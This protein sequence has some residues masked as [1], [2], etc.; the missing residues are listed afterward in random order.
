MDE[1]SEKIV[2]APASE[3]SSGRTDRSSVAAHALDRQ[4]TTRAGHVWLLSGFVTG[5]GA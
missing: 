4:E 1:A 3:K 5:G 2:L